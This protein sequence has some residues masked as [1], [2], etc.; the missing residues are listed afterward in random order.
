MRLLPLVL[1]GTACAPAPY[2]GFEDDLTSRGGC[3]DLL[4][5]ARNA[6]DTIELTV[7]LE[8]VLAEATASGQD[9]SIV[10]PFP[11]P[12]ATL[13]V[14][15]GRQVGDATCDDVIENGGPEVL[16]TWVPVDGDGTVYIRPGATLDQ[17]RA[18][19]ILSDIELK[20]E[21][22]GPS[23]VLEDL[24]IMDVAVGWFAG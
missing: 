15:T 2:A 13:L 1:L 10:L 12:R 19:L 14:R 21:A 22:G 8:G 3:G 9:T 23:V 4:F 16:T 24:A 20:P 6:E 17:A 5:Y 7:R 18:D 11:T